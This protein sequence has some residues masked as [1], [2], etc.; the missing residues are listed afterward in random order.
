MIVTTTSA[1]TEL[2]IFSN[3]SC[4]ELISNGISIETDVNKKKVEKIFS[5][6]F[7]ISSAITYAPLLPFSETTSLENIQTS[8]SGV[9]SYITENFE[10]YLEG[11][12]TLN[13]YYDLC[14]LADDIF[15]D[16]LPRDKI[17]T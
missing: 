10:S 6:G 14:S 4:G 2:S 8:I 16:G 1:R 7:S 3:L 5:G 9:E 11:L 12:M 13:Q 15:K 17:K